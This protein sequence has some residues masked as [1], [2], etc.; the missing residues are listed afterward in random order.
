M[1]LNFYGG[2]NK[3]G[4]NKILVDNKDHSNSS[5]NNISSLFLD[6]GMSFSKAGDY[7]SEFLQPRKLNGIMDFIEL[8]L[9]PK[10][11]GIYREDY[12]KHCGINS[13]KEPVVDGVLLSHAHMDHCSH[14]HHLREDIPIFMRKESEIILQV[15]EDTGKTSFSE[16]MNTKKSFHYVPKKRGEGYKKLTG[17]EAKIKR[18]IE[19]IKPYSPFEINDFKVTSIPVDHS[20]PGA[21]AYFLENDNE[22]IVYS[23]DIRF[24]GRNQEY[25][26]KFLT[27][28][29]KFNPTTMF[30]EGTR[31]NEDTEKKIETEEDIEFEA[32]N[33]IKNHEGLIIVNYPIRDL[34]RLV[35]FHNIAKNTDRIL[36]INS[37]QA[38][39]LKLL[40]NE[41]DIETNKYPKLKDPNIA[42]YFPRKKQGLIS[43]EH[44]V[45]YDDDW[46]IIDSEDDEVKKDY[47]TWE[48]E[49]LDEDN[50]INYTN[51][52]EDP[53]KYIFRCDFFEL[54]QLID[55]KPENGL[56]IHSITEPFNEEM[57]FDFK[58]VENWLN[59]FNLPIYKMHVSG[60]G[61]GKEI[62]NMIRE[63]NPEKIYPIHTEH[64]KLFDILRDDGIT[65]I[66][67]ELKS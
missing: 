14:I 17:D 32:T 60:H 5:E 47:E 19:T 36:A 8:G 7:F 64:A 41:K 4:G 51:L 28:A 66:H 13:Y 27:E 10:I 40:E 3:I 48:R 44:C 52:K 24:H 43:G 59:H 11:K 31:I 22:T 2:V 21:C 16:I 1:S 29:Q 55:I 42:V 26:N 45:A 20:L 53:K 54:N 33:T 46:K 67:P 63:I 58:R 39:I 50:A 18:T 15:L 38:Y 61:K 23:G 49:F 62:L 35:T 6:F 9:L 57:G 25:S 30:C 65:V 12:L 56:Y 37:K 34:D